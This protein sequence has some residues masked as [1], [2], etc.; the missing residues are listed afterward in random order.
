MIRHLLQCFDCR[1]DLA[2]KIARVKGELAA[3]QFLMDH[4]QAKPFD[5]YTQWNQHADKM[6]K[7]EAL[8]QEWSAF[9]KKLAT[10]QN[11]DVAA[12]KKEI[13]RA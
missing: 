13:D 1:D 11:R 12:H 4:Y 7:L 3:V 5:P 8:K 2:H 6:N 10:L 9:S